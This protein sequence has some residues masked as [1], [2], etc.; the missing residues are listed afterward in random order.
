M[1]NA[2]LTRLT[3][4]INQDGVAMLT[5]MIYMKNKWNLEIL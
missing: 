2:H 4:D 5:D 1:T 3:N